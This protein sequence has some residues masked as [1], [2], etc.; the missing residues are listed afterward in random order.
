MMS[1]LTSDDQFART[2]DG[3]T[4]CSC[5]PAAAAEQSCRS[6]NPQIQRTQKHIGLTFGAT[7]FPTCKYFWLVTIALFLSPEVAVAQYHQC[8]S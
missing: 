6:L 4:Y 8:F 5:G 1:E 3:S 7:P 2:L